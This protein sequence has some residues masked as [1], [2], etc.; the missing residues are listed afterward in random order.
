MIKIN[1]RY[2]I[3]LI[4]HNLTGD[5]FMTKLYLFILFITFSGFTYAKDLSFQDSDGNQITCQT[6]EKDG[7]LNC[8]N[9]NGD[10][11][12]CS[13]SDQNGFTCSADN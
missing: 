2:I 3:D 1:K 12:I 11:V 6:S 7:S 9:T 10:V 4:L 13:N 5:F 8:H